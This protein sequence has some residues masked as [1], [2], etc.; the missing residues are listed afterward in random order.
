MHIERREFLGV[1]FDPVSSDQALARLAEVTGETP[2]SYVVTPN[3]DHVVRLHDKEWI[4]AKLKAIYD[5]ADL[6]LCDSKVLHVLAR[7]RGVRLPVVVGTDLASLVFDRLVEPGD[8]IAIVGGSDAMVRILEQ[9]YPRVEFVQHNPP[10]DL[11]WN[12]AARRAAAE[13]IAESGA[14]F[15]FI[16]SRF[17]A[18]GADRG[19][20]KVYFR[21][22]RNSFLHR[23]RTGFYHW[24]AAPRPPSRP[25][26]WTRMG[27]PTRQQSAAHVAALSARRSARVHTGL[28]VGRRPAPQSGV[29]MNVRVTPIAAAPRKKPFKWVFPAALALLALALL[30]AGLVANVNR[31][32]DWNRF[33]QLGRNA[34]TAGSITVALPNLVRPL[35]PEQA[36]EQNL[37][38]PFD[39]AP[40]TPAQKFQLK[41]DDAS[42][43]R[44]LECL[45]QAIYYEAATEGPE[46]QRAVAQVVLNRMHHPGFP[47]TVCGVV[48]QGSELP[49]G[50]PVHLH[51]R[52]LPR[53]DPAPR[54]LGAG[55]ADRRRSAR[56]ARRCRGRSRD[57]LPRRLCR[58]LLGGL[59]PQAG[60]DRPSYF[61]SAEGHPRLQRRILAALRRG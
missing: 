1:R 6:C 22:S 14:R 17:A 40:D 37:E 28:S 34:P 54:H 11:R 26:A 58:S 33:R 21:R 56:R 32:E 46:G 39:A 51:L 53:A 31:H 60:A 19:G 61:L 5:E 3:V 43:E 42:R 45:A 50:L 52:W 49:T 23:R 12:S 47:P 4:E 18:A 16:G 29:K 55:K 24:P 41:A 9:K 10:M 8:R 15:S 27:A 48:Y 38:R 30:T 57:P 20:G 2:Y 44:A 13:F 36:M 25:P 59:V 7:F 35:T